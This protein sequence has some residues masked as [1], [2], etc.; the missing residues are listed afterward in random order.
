MLRRSSLLPFL[1][2]AL[3]LMLAFVTMLAVAI[4]WMN[5]PT[6][7]G[8]V[9][10]RSI[11]MLRLTWPDDSTADIDLWIRGPNGRVVGYP[12]KDGGYMILAR[13]DL[14]TSNDT[15]YAD[16]KKKVLLRNMEN[17]TIT[18]P[19]P[20][21]YVV[22]VHYYSNHKNAKAEIPVELEMTQLTPFTV[23]ANPKRK[24]TFVKEKIAILSFVITPDGHVTDLITSLNPVF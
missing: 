23:V 11:L 6:T 7:G 12:R 22:Q 3:A 16:G 8:L 20:G 15:V 9:D 4:L 21:E 10:P 17:I 24:L 18:M 2:M 5:V 1:D 14:G 13:D 19:I